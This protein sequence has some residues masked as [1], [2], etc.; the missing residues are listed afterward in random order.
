MPIRL[1]LL[2]STV[3]PL[4]CGRGPVKITPLPPLPLYGAHA[5][6]V[7]F[8]RDGRPEDYL[9]S[10]QLRC[11]MGRVTVPTCDAFGAGK[12]IDLLL[13]TSGFFSSPRRLPGLVR[14]P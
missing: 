6:A 3:L 14:R 1:R 2:A 5:R 8:A 7:V 11:K 10:C 13:R 12:C 4:Q 9:L